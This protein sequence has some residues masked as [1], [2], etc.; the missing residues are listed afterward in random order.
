MH[1]R[2][3]P[4]PVFHALEPV[5]EPGAPFPAFRA[6]EQSRGAGNPAGGPVFHDYSQDLIDLLKQQAEDSNAGYQ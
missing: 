6:L 2:L 4:A 1:I 3:Y 5:A